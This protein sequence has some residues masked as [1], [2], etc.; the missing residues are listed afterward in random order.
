MSTAPAH[1]Y[2]KVHTFL[3]HHPMGILSTVTDDGN[4][5]GSAIYY[6]ADENFNFYFVTRVGTFKYHNLDKNPVASLTIADSES[7]IT[8]QVSGKI[9]KV[10]VHEYMDIVFDKLAAIKP[11]DDEYW[12]PPLT[13]INKG[14]YMPLLLTPSR[15]QYANYKQVKSDIHADYIE[16][17]IP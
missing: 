15:L 10:P 4:P 3:R 8:V 2:Q 16:K 17:I 12:L 6:V 13:K 11:K 1:P 5:W 7:Q 9:S 14:N